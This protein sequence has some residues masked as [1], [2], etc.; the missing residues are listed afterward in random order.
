MKDSTASL[1]SD[2]VIEWRMRGDKRMLT[3]EL[4]VERNVHC[5]D[6]GTR[7]QGVRVGSK[8]RFRHLDPSF[9]PMSRMATGVTILMK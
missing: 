8:M 1:S 9:S 4:P 3:Q 5:E 7:R 2:R 6:L